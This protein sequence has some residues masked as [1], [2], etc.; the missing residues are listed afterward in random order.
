MSLLTVFLFLICILCFLSS[1]SLFKEQYH[2][3]GA[4]AG[5]MSELEAEQYEDEE[6][7]RMME[8]NKRWNEEVARNR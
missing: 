6:H 1:R 8:V 2:Q 7:K 5:A 4:S 3:K